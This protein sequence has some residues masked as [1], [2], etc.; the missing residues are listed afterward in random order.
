M[1]YVGKVFIFKILKDYLSLNEFKFMIK[2]TYFD[3]KFNY[4]DMSMFLD[5]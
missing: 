1:N 5:S 4:Y 2:Q 3:I